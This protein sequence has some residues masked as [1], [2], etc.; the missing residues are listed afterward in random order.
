MTKRETHLE[1]FGEHK[2]IHSI[3]QVTGSYIAYRRE[4]TR[5]HGELLDAFD[6]LLADLQVV[7]I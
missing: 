2:R 4:S 7:R 6:Q 3:V 1:S 5:R